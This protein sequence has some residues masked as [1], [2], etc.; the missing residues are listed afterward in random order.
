M[1][2]SSLSFADRGA[3][4]VH[5][6][7]DEPVIGDVPEHAERVH[8]APGERRVVVAKAEDVSDTR[9]RRYVPAADQGEWEEGF[10]RRYGPD[11]LT[12]QGSR[13]PF[14]VD[15]FTIEKVGYGVFVAT[16]ATSP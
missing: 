16:L 15:L 5:N 7:N 9:A 10:A 6:H 2:T 1:P 11:E 4:I 13:T 3:A 8:P 12:R 14:L